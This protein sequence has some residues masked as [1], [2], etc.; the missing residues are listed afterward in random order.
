MRFK[1]PEPTGPC[2]P[3]FPVFIPFAGCRERCVFCSQ[4]SQ[5][6]RASLPDENL[7]DFL[8]SALAGIAGQKHERAFELAYYGGTFT[9]LPPP[10]MDFFMQQAAGLKAA[11]KIS[12]LRCSTRPDAVTPALLRRLKDQG[13]DTMELGIQSFC[14]LPLAASQR[15]YCGDTAIRACHMVMEAGL[16]LGVQLMPGMPGMSEND[17]RRDAATAAEIKPDFIRLYPCLVLENTILADIWRSGAFTPWTLEL[18]LKILP[19]A[20]LLFW[21]KGIRVIRLGLAPQPGLRE[22]ILAGPAHPALGQRLRSLA[23][24]RLIRLK[25]EQYGLQLRGK[26]FR[27][28]V[29]RRFQ[30]EF[31]GHG[32][33]LKAAWAE[34]GLEPANVHWSDQ[35]YFELDQ[36]KA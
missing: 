23:L 30:G 32:G 9:A 26:S 7:P 27:F 24:H 2:P 12:R 10:V 21:E 15:N 11:G 4:E 3:I 8:Q 34:M 6:G 31:Y 17:F 25:V 1:H 33:E 36:G 19:E 14:D 29:P 18:V 35:E 16:R 20:L 13:L 5:T 28:R 22:N